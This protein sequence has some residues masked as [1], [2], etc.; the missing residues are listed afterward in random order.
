MLPLVRLKTALENDREI[1]NFVQGGEFYLLLDELAGFDGKA[2]A[3]AI[4]DAM[5]HRKYPRD[6]LNQAE[7]ALRH[8]WAKYDTA[9]KPTSFLRKATA[10]FA[11]S[12]P[13][14]PINKALLNAATTALTAAEVTRLAANPSMRREW[15]ARAKA[16]FDLYV[17]RAKPKG[18]VEKRDYHRFELPDTELLELEF[19]IE[20]QYGEFDSN[21]H[22]FEEAYSAQ[23]RL[24]DLKGIPEL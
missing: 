14:K 22:S 9:A 6:Q 12:G 7:G 19:G 15:L 21:V 17:I 3:G 18:T 20:R 1:Y 10:A 5:R 24:P 13:E 11:V 23:E 8:A 2:A 16:A 4:D